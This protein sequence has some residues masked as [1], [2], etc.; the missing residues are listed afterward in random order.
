MMHDWRLV[1]IL[2]DWGKGI[3]TI[4]FKDCKSKEVTLVASGFTDLH[5]PKQ[6]K[7]GESISVNRMAGP[8][9]LESG[10]YYVELEIQSGDK[11]YLEAK[12]IQV[13][14]LSR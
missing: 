3:V 6:E 10:N 5:I 2:I 12:S 1:S 7:W 4:T 14:T 8:I 13:P 11:L 9:L